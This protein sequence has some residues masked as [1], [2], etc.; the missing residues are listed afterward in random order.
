MLAQ[1]LE[2]HSRS[3]STAAGP[4]FSRPGCLASGP[5]RRV[6]GGDHPMFRRRFHALASLDQRPRP[7]R[8]HRHDTVTTPTPGTSIRATGPPF[9]DIHSSDRRKIHPCAVKPANWPTRLRPGRG[10]APAK[11]LHLVSP[12]LGLRPSHTLLPRRQPAQA[13]AG[14]ATLVELLLERRLGRYRLG[15]VR[16]VRPRTARWITV[17][18]APSMPARITMGCRRRARVPPEASIFGANP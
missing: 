16:A 3:V 18:W 12:G 5:R 6:Q 4:R 13:R 11:P 2:H 9:R 7:V 8:F 1:R 14:G 17:I 15:D 10:R